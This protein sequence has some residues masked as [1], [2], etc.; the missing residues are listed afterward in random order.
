M[1]TTHSTATSPSTP[2]KPPTKPRHR[3]NRAGAATVGTEEAGCFQYLD[4]RT[5]RAIERASRLLE[6][7]VVYRTEAAHCPAD[8]KAYL[9]LKMAALE[10]EEFHVIW[11]DSQSRII[12]FERLFSGSVSETVV[13]PRE[14]VKAAMRHN[15]SACILAHNHPSGIAAPSISDEKL[16]ATLKAAL[17]LVGVRINDH[18]IVAGND[19]PL[20]FAERGLL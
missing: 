2:P 17:G 7:S 11:L 1:A 18:F 13:Y 6:K 5:R 9:K 20:S 10:H 15:A 8:V 19:S 4:V 12:A 14:V 3:N 16:T